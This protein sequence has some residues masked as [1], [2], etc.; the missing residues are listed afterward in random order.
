M[1]LGRIELPTN[2]CSEK[3]RARCATI[4]FEDPV[5]RSEDFYIVRV[6]RIELAL[7]AWEAHVL[8]L[9]YTRNGII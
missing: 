5:A 1:R 7:Y 4:F 2:A 8:P 9:N 6:A 3:Y